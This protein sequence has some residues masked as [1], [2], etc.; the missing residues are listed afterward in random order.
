MSQPRTVLPADLRAEYLACKEEIDRA[1]H[2]V[3][4]S[5]WYI[6]GE[7]V[8]GFEDSFARFLGV[9]HA[10]GVASGTDALHLAL[11][12]CGVGPGDAVLTVSHTAVATVAAIELAG[13]TPVFVDVDPVR[14][15]MDPEHLEAVITGWHRQR[16]GGKVAKLKAVIPVHLY[17]QPADMPAICRVAEEYDLL[18]I[19]DASQAHGAEIADRKIGTWGD[20]AAFSCY[21]TKNLGAMGDAGVLV[22]RSDALAEKARLLRE[23]GWRE[24]YISELPGMNSRLDPIQ[25]AV[26]SVKL[27]HLP[28]STRRRREIAHRYTELLGDGAP[29]VPPVEYA[30][31]MHVYHQY[32]VRTS[33]RDALRDY[34]KRRGIGTQVHY[35]MPVHLQPAYRERLPLPEG[36]LP[37]TESVCRDIVSLPV[38]PHLADSDVNAVAAAI[39]AWGRSGRTGG[40]GV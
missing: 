28:E 10:A 20:V 18:V 22:S 17:G 35:P 31:C 29:V 39:R 4:E 2:D 30:D 19:E 38:G 27:R 6:G 33:Q 8:A 26:L 13:A 23:Y 25:A 9:D 12:A 36:G 5:G 24:R 15:T 1:I 16:S 21:P 7:T 14:F 32:V 37:A 3:L 11:R 34:L 40:G